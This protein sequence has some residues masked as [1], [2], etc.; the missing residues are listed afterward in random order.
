VGF[1][2][3]EMGTRPHYNPIGDYHRTDPRVRMRPGGSAQVDRTSHQLGGTATT[4]NRPVNE[5]GICVVGW[6]VP[7]QELSLSVRPM[8][9]VE[10]LPAASSTL[11]LFGHPV[12]GH[13]EVCQD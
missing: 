3:P 13:L 7:R 11:S 8:R 6:S 2:G 9:F 4:R 5:P 1:A 10:K 12:C